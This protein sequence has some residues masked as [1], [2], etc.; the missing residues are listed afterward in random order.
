MGGNRKPPS[1]APA[2]KTILI[3]EDQEDILALENEVLSGLGYHVIGAADPADALRASEGFPGE[4]HLL[5]TDVVLTGMRGPELARLIANQRPEMKLL[6]VS[7][8]AGELEPD[9]DSLILE[10]GLLRKPFA[11]EVLVDAVRRCLQA[12]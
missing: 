10:S 8:S 7:G 1:L 4:I 6:F 11:A 12:G 3:V 2:N 5:L 9:R